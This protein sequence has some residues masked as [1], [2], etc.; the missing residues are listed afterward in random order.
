MLK[1]K[2]LDSPFTPENE[3][4]FTVGFDTALGHNVNFNWWI[5]N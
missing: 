2:L 3:A 1:G 4:Q 5:V